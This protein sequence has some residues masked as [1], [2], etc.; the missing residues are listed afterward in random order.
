MAAAW[1]TGIPGMTTAAGWVVKGARIMFATLRRKVYE[2]ILDEGRAEANAEWQ[3]W[4]QRR[5]NTGVFVPDPDDPP[6][7]PPN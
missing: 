1:L 7:Y 6:P 3:A 5:T 2:Q 4:W